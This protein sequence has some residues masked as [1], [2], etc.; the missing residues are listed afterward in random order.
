MKRRSRSVIVSLSLGMGMALVSSQAG[1]FYAQTNLVS[2]IPGVA[3]AT[4]PNLVNPWGMSSSPTSPI[5]VSDNGANVSTLYNG[6]GTRQA[7]VVTIPDGAPTGQ[8]FNNTT[9]FVVGANPA[10]FIFASENGAIDAWNGGAVA[11]I[12]VPQGTVASA[13]YK[14]LA[15]DSAS[16]RLYATDF[17]NNKVDVFDSSFAPVALGGCVYRSKPA[18]G[19]RAV[20]DTEHWR[21]AVCILCAA[22]RPGGGA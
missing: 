15:I 5:W 13:V 8:V 12:V 10:R 18:L 17:H 20:R 7:L 16:S 9:G 4:D 22:G 6:A 14:G 1:A 21:Q 2:D 3:A 19:L 11:A